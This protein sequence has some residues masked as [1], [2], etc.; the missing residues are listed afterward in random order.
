[1]DNTLVIFFSDNG[2]FMLEG[3]GK[4]VASNLPLRGGGVTLW[5]G[6]IRVP[7][8]V[9]WPGVLP[10]GTVCREPFFSCDFFP[11]IVFAAGGRLP[12]DREIDGR[13]PTA[14]LAGAASSPHEAFYFRYRRYSA[15]R[16]GR[17]K[18]LRTGPQE[19][20]QLFDL[21]TDV[22]EM[23]DLAAERPELLERLSEQHQQWEASLP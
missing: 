4:E 9:R 18:L 2:A 16:A 8:L 7:C 23:Q 19:P 1:R 14:M 13:D 12:E 10:A 22:G 15:L 20:F 11:M 3:R 21:Q 17:Y 5:E 6:G